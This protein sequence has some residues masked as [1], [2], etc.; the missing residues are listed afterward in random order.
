MKGGFLVAFLLLAV[1]LAIAES[2]VVSNSANWQDVYS[3]MLYGNL[4]EKTPYFLVSS[5]HSALLA[6]QLPKTEEGILVISSRKSPYA[7]GYKGLLESKG[8]SCEEQQY[9]NINLEMAKRL[10]TTK[11]VMIDDSYGYNAISVAPYA[12]IS[13]SYVLFANKKN[14][15]QVAAF[16]EGRRPTKIIL[17]GQL[18]KEVKERLSQYSP[19]TINTGD[20]FEDNHKIVDK[21]QEVHKQKNGKHKSQVI[22]T[23]GEFI[24]QEIMS[25][26]EPVVFI[27]RSNVPDPVKDYIQKSDIEIGILIGNELIGSAT[28]I[29]RQLGISVFV[30]FAQSAR[31]PTGP[32]SAVED[33]DRFYLPRYILDLELYE[34]RYNRP[35]SQLLVTYHNNVPLSSYLKG[36]VTVRYGEDTQTVGDLDAVFI[37]KSEYRTFVY[38]LEP[39]SSDDITAEVFT[40][41]GDSKRSLEYTLRET[42]DVET[43]TISD[44]SK[45]EIAEVA[46]DQRGGQFLIKIRNIGEVDAFVDLEVVDLLLNDEL[47][48]AGSEEITLVKVGKTSTIAVPAEMDDEDMENNPKASIKAYYG[49]REQSL[50]NILSGEYEYSMAGFGL[51]GGQMLAGIG[52]ALISYGPMLVIGFLLLLIVGMKKKCP[53]CK[54]VNPLR[55]KHC[56]KCGKRI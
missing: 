6:D 23:N 45:I 4:A 26:V 34:V 7:F 11:F 44:N 19:E 56:S 24:E 15:N 1:P 16:L 36:T 51:V 31:T 2:H 47:V 8:L 27:G 43:V 35:Q 48:T 10:D 3:V 17:Y 41:Y 49:E 30:K 22:L 52:G 20:R 54:Q 39:I 9:D 55:A 37:D 13:D 18:D 28:F 33:L 46:Y 21:F 50:I 12:V 5:R 53:S 25:G 42:V 29:R 32:V 38:D 14:I 40:I